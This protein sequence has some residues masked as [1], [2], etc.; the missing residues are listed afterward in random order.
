MLD[1]LKLSLTD[2]YVSSNPDLQVQPPTVNLGTG[3]VV[4]S[5]LLW[6]SGGREVV[7][8]KAFHNGEDV[9][10]TLRPSDNKTFTS[11]LCLVQ[12]SV[13]KVVTGSNYHAT[14]YKGTEAA[15]EAVQ[16][17]LD[18]VG[19]K[20]NVKTA[21]VSRLDAFKTVEADEGFEAYSPVL[22]MLKGQ[23][24]A[25]RDYGTTFLW[26]NTQSEICAYDK[27]EEMSRRKQSVSHLPT[28]SVRFEVRALKGRKVRDWLGISSAGELPQ[29][30]DHVRDC[31]NATMQKH[32]FKPELSEHHVLRAKTIEA[33]LLQVMGTERYWFRSWLN[34]VALERLAP[35]LEAV[36]VAIKALPASRPQRDR[37]LRELEQARIDAAALRVLGP[38]KRPIGELYSELREKVL[39]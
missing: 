31:Y 29:A 1:T 24:M 36:K 26:A 2:Y 34:A 8:A 19:I 5:N 14:D 18:K 38:S 35:E 37:I 17:Y 13:P 3:E 12:F 39:A 6:R 10:I 27:L 33:Q 30:L 16:K 15:L 23:R 22:S 9:N 11:A 25:K 20:T 32:L 28:N 4:G 21:R 7:G